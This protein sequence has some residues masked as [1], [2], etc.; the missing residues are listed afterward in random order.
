MK[1]KWQPNMMDMTFN[2]F[3]IPTYEQWRK[4]AEKS[5]KGKSFED[6]LLT[7][8]L[9]DIVLQPMYQLKDLE[10]CKTFV[11]Q[12]GVFPYVRG[13]TIEPKRMAI[14]QELGAAT[15]ALLHERI[16]QDFT[17]GQ[18]VAHILISNE[19]KNGGKSNL[20]EPFSTVPLYDLNDV[21]KAF[22]GIDFSEFP[23]HI[24]AG[25]VSVPLLAAINHVT[26]RL[27]GTIASDPLH[28][29][30]KEGR[31]YYPL[32]RSYDLMAW[33]V[34]WA[35]ANHP[36]L[37]T[38][39]AQSHVF[40]NGGASPALELASTLSMGVEYI[41]A[42]MKRG[43]SAT[44]AGQSITFSFSIGKD[45]FSEIA[46]VR[47]ARAL[48]AVIMAEFGAEE[49]GQKMVIHART[50]SFTKTKEDMYV[51]VL[52]GTSESFAAAVAGVNSVS[53]SPIDELVQEPTE[54]SSR[55]ARN[56]SL[57][58]RDEAYIGATIDPAGGS[59]FVEHLTEKI[60]KKAWGIFQ[61]LEREGGMFASLK[62][63]LVQT[64]IDICWEKQVESVKD[65]RQTIVGVNQYVKGSEKKPPKQRSKKAERKAYFDALNEKDKQMIQEKPKTIAEVEKLVQ[66]NIPFH[67][68][69]HQLKTPCQPVEVERILQRRLAEPYELLR[70]RSNQIK[71]TIGEIPVVYIVRLG[72]IASHKTRVDFIE[73]LFQC[74]GFQVEVS[75]PMET[76]EEAIKLAKQHKLVVLCGSDESY[77]NVALSI[78]K[79]LTQETKTVYI[80]G[81]QKEPFMKQLM[82]AGM[83]GAIH[84]KTN[85]YHFLFD[86]QEKIGGSKL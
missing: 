44:E 50:S 86:L 31:M 45:F 70:T 78:V 30:A 81:R 59:W 69:H 35:I 27:T 82:D 1:P 56:T 39:L 24:D 23:F 20:E 17:K 8:L 83:A 53:V 26:N 54:F 63:G 42:L 9:D 12:P 18:N 85:A 29:L 67:Q 76:S 49:T 3:P 19:M 80:A 48:W 84:A 51:N 46:K 72:S 77:E 11:N 43:V 79:G 57:I 41:E 36:D 71:E 68:I 40:H 21:K 32:E 15:P 6:T 5:L 55:I 33:A 7:K 47:A 16:K 37:R 14:S 75:N 22:Q 64:K 62:N 10:A 34:K 58:L 4:V 13:I 65:R 2:E 52:R 66:Q 38:V 73:E 61:E 28:Q 60:A 25:V 74:G